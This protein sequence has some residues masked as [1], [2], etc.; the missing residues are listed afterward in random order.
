M[1]KRVCLALLIVCLFVSGVSDFAY[2]TTEYGAAKET[3]FEEIEAL[4]SGTG[5]NT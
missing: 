4:A 3:D 1:L 5:W 2:A